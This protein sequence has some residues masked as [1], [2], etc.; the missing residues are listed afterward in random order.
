MVGPP[1]LGNMAV[2]KIFGVR[3]R[4]LV[5]FSRGPN[6]PEAAEL[7]C[8]SKDVTLRSN[9]HVIITIRLPNFKLWSGS[10]HSHRS[11]QRIAPSAPGAMYGPE[12]IGSS[13]GS[14]GNHSCNL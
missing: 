11:R 4:L 10:G 2:A 9:S 1:L 3:L 14:P 7:R 5:R 12:N 8:S 6:L 13:R